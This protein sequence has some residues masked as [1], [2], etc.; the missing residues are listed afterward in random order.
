MTII[1]EVV[2]AASAAIVF[3]T[4]NQSNYSKE[5]FCGYGYSQCRSLE[6]KLRLRDPDYELYFLNLWNL[7]LQ[8]I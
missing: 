5:L 1:F 7:C 2:T 8:I 6:N 4:Y 3:L